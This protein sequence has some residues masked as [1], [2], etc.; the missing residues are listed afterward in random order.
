MNIGPFRPSILKTILK[1]HNPNFSNDDLL[2][3]YTVS[4]GVPKYV[5]LLMDAGA[6]SSEKMMDHICS[7]GSIFITDGKELLVSEFG[8]D[9]MIYFSI[10]QLIAKG[11]NTL[12]E[13]NDSTKKECGTYLEN[14][15]KKY[16]V[17][18]K[19]RPIF[20]EGN[21]R[22]VRWQISDNYLRFYF[23]FI[24]VNMSAVEFQRYDVL[25]EVILAGY[26]DHSGRVLEEY[27]KNKMAEEERFT[28]IGSYWDRKGENEI[29]LI[30][31]NG[32]DKKAVVAE[33]KRNPKKANINSLMKRSMA[34]HGLNEYDIEYK[35][36]SLEDM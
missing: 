35:I 33:V 21:S 18:K 24:S 17:I 1:D 23:K 20:S 29:D 7:P 8:T 26:A 5:E 16:S 10:L 19:N 31:L 36:L 27:F 9:H 4:G 25:K 13:I 15:E 14:L 6:A 12:K 22:D 32:I 28:G 34:V 30:V 3:L 2:F 11:K